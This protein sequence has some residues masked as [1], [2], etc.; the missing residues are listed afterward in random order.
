MYSQMLPISGSKMTSR[1][2]P[3]SEEPVDEDDVKKCGSRSRKGLSWRNWIRGR[4][5]QGIAGKESDLRI[6]LSVLGCPLFPITPHQKKQSDDEASSS[7]QY[8]I[9]HFTAATGCRKLD[10]RVKS[11]FV[12]GK[13]TMAMADEDVAGGTGISRRK[14]CFVMWQM[15]PEKWLIELVV[16]EQK[17]VAGSD[18]R[19][20]WRHTPWLGTHAAKGGVR[21]LRRALQGLDPVA[22][23]E[24]FGASQYMGEK[25]IEGTDC[26]ILRLSADQNELADR[27]DGTA[28]MIKHSVYGYFSQ[29]NGLL[30][31]L[32]DSFLTRIH[33][34]GTNP[35][36]W[37]TTMSTAIYD[38]RPIE[39]GV[40]IAHSGRSSAAISRF[41]EDLRTGPVI[42]R[43]E[44]TWS[45]D[46]FALD[47]AGLSVDSFIPPKDVR[48]EFW[49]EDQEWK[50]PLC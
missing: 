14:G 30:V 36:Y 42:T 46:D 40:L 44:E 5:F 39:C 21:P 10:G 24:V 34:P 48:Q 13:V 4:F 32:E 43:M 26:F 29:R 45:I 37:E 12:T 3:V 49:D 18:G 2:A 31:H 38:Y 11:V 17:V 47:V 41:G 27:S 25:E 1:L 8:I 20:A 15:V 35:T 23:A 6:L 16:G 22:I 19:M 9:Q 28:E 33:S 7:A 50:P